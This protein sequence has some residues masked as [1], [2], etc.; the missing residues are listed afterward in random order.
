MSAPGSYR[1]ACKGTVLELPSGKLGV[2]FMTKIIVEYLIRIGLD[3]S[4]DS[5]VW[6]EVDPQM[7]DLDRHNMVVGALVQHGIATNMNHYLQLT[8]KGVEMYLKVAEA[9]L[10]KKA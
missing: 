10:V 9:L 8:P 7:A 5:H 4:P 6:M 2:L 3:G 1:M